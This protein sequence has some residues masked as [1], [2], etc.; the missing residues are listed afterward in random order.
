[1][2]HIDS[3]RYSIDLPASWLV[4]RADGSTSVDDQVAAAEAAYPEMATFIERQRDAFLGNDIV[5]L[6]AFDPA[7]HDRGTTFE[8]VLKDYPQAMFDNAE[9]AAS[10]F[11]K[12]IGNDG[13]PVNS[14]DVIH[15]PGGD[16]ARLIYTRPNADGVQLD[17]NEY[18]LVGETHSMEL[19]FA[20]SAGFRGDY[21]ALY[22]DVV[23]SWRLAAIQP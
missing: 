8:A 7:A 6:L 2:Q 22:D 4:L 16:A 5:P 20:V 17:W 1:M 18:F 21:E 15:L 10:A 19:T 13:D 14:A 3:P 9:E 11:A 12:V 23:K